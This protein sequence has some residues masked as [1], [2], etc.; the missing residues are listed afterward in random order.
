MVLHPFSLKGC[1]VLSR[2]S[3]SRCWCVFHVCVC[4]V[5]WYVVLFRVVRVFV[6]SVLLCIVV[7][8]VCLFSLITCVFLLCLSCIEHC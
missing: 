4:C 7:C 1:V 2:V 6:L 3:L 8:Y 5:V